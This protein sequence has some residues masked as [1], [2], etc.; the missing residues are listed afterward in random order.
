[1]GVEAMVLLLSA[2][3]GA[4]PP[5]GETSPTTPGATAAAPGG[6]ERRAFWTI[7]CEGS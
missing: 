4:A 7:V 6:V 1:L 3:I 2:G 5:A